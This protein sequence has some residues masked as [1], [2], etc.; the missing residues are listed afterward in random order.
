MPEFSVTVG[1]IAAFAKGTLVGPP[2]LAISGMAGLAEAGPGDLSF[3][4]DAAAAKDT[5]STRATALL[6]PRQIE[7]LACAQIVVAHPALTMAR[8]V[9]EFF[10]PK[11]Q[12]LGLLQP[13]HRGKDVTIG[14]GVSVWPFVT[15]CDQVSIGHHTTLYPH[16]FIGE[17]SVI[18]EDCVLH[19][20]VTIREGVTIGNRVIIHAGTVVGSDGFGYLQ[21]GGRHHKI[22]QVG[23]VVIEDDVELGANVTVDRATFGKTI[24]R[25][26]TK[27]DNL[28]QIAHNVEIGEHNILVSQVGIAGSSKTG[29]HVIVGGQAGISDHVTIG[30]LAM[31]AA[32]SGLNR[33]VPPKEVVAGSPAQ[34][35]LEWLK[36][37]AIVAKLP[38]F[39]QQVKNLE[40]RLKALEAKTSTKSVRK[41][42]AKRKRK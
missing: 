12:A 14:N 2:D 21:E 25:K 8:I 34:P 31:I 9:E 32:R 19:P 40:E 15:L 35:R 26:G 29:H 11:R 36:S 1:Q 23:T 24:I 27:V 41:P 39:R 22:P 5:L 33:D 3:L 17:G 16:V 13:I 38:E 4:A 10:V 20:N 6:V 30:D 42:K 18:G 7:Q 28:V 37:M